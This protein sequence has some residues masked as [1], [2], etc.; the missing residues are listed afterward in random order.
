MGN[1]H[2]L[3][4]NRQ[5]IDIEPVANTADI[6]IPLDLSQ[7][8]ITPIHITVST[9]NAPF[10]PLMCDGKLKVA[11]NRDILKC[12]RI[13][14]RH[15]HQGDRIKPFGLNGSKLV[16]DLFADL[17]L[18]HAAKREAWILE[19]DGDILWVLGHRAAALYPVEPE[20]QDYILLSI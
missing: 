4:I 13:I 5:S 6:E 7:D 16:S 20:S 10:S 8:V 14:L 9:N 1:G 3:H 17:K 15:W 2:A 12:Q 18:D 11:F 19:A